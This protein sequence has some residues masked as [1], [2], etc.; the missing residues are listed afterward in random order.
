[1][2]VAAGWKLDDPS[3]VRFEIPVDGYDAE[4]WNGITD[5]CLY[6]HAANVLA[7]N[8][9]KRACR[10]PRNADE[11]LYHY[12]TEIAK[13]QAYAPFGF[14]SNGREIWFWE[15]GMANPR[16]IAGFF[17]PE[18][19]KRMLFLRQHAHPLEATSIN[20]SIVDRP[21]QHEAIR[22]VCEAFAAKRRRALL[23][24][25]TGTGKTRTAMALIDLFLRAHQAQNVLFLA[26]RD[27][28]VD[29]ALTDG[30]KAHLPN[31]PRDRI[32][33]WNVDKTMR[34]FV[35]TEQTMSL[36][37]EKFSPLF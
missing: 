12:V 3:L 14:M 33:T 6:D 35:A 11:Q 37:Y 4:P 16:L 1:M 18:D 15:V 28:L 13:R 10:S 5:Y 32:Y 31:E 30:F 21:Y 20:T 24:K 17:S 2:L 34:L 27:A 26:D 9:A 29:Q 7:V 19:L 23:V 22:R 8:E 25:A 36:C